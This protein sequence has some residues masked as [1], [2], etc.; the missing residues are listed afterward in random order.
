MIKAE[1]IAVGS[2]LLLGGRT[3]MN[4]VFLAEL[5]AQEGIEVRFKTVVGDDIKDICAAIS[6]ASKRAR[7]VMV[8]GGLGPTVDDLTREAVA[9]L[10]R[11]SLRFRSK[12]FRSIEVRFRAAGKTISEN[13]RRQAF[14]PIGS[15]V[16]Q[17]LAGTAPGFSIK[18]KRSQ[19]F[20]LPGV[21]HEARAMFMESVLP[22]LIKE[23]LVEEAI[24]SRFIHTF[25]LIEGAIDEKVKGIVTEASDIRLG[26]LASPLGVSVSLTRNPSFDAKKTNIQDGDGRYSKVLLEV[27]L[28]KISSKLGYHV[29]GF[30]GQTMEQIIGDTLVS[31]GLKLALAESCTGGLIGHRLTEVAGS[32]R[33][34]DRGVLCY[35]NQAKIDLVGVPKSL[36]LKFGAVSGQ[37]AKAMAQGI[38][39]QSSVDIGLSV[40]GIAGPRG[41]TKAKPVGLVFVGLATPQKIY[42]KEFRFHG[43]RSTIKLRSS[44]GALDVLRRWL[45]NLPIT[46]E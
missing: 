34:V 26:M 29:F 40:T 10:T 44:Q 24:E 22:L 4:S 39:K 20:C 18:W 36:L 2:E 1:I 19:I 27:Y 21:S 30:D 12:V 16:L 43:D 8:T 3:D 25:G 45:L 14:L 11:N 9:K 28:K 42:T 32:S 46:D 35:S 33:Y 6:Q 13:Q 31:C 23:K 37:V 7:V 41:G 38:Q 17:N 15:D 5:L